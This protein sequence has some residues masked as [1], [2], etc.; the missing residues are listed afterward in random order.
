[1][2][3][4]FQDH[5]KQLIEFEFNSGS[6]QEIPFANMQ[7][8]TL[9]QNVDPYNDVGNLRFGLKGESFL[10]KY[11]NETPDFPMLA[12]GAGNFGS[13]KTTVE[14]VVGKQREEIY[15][16]ANHQARFF[17][18]FTQGERTQVP[19]IMIAPYKNSEL[20]NLPGSSFTVEI[21]YYPEKPA[22]PNDN[23]CNLTLTGSTYLSN[24]F[25]DSDLLSFHSISQDQAVLHNVYGNPTMKDATASFHYR[26][27][28]DYDKIARPTGL[29]SFASERP[30]FYGNPKPVLEIFGMSGSDG[31]H[32]VD[33]FPVSLSRNDPGDGS[34]PPAWKRPGVLSASVGY[35]LSCS[36]WN[37]S[38][39]S[40]RTGSYGPYTSSLKFDQY[41][42]KNGFI[43]GV[44][45]Y[46][47][48]E[49]GN[50]HF[51]TWS[52]DDP[53]Q[54]NNNTTGSLWT[55]VTG[56]QN[57]RKLGKNL[58]LIQLGGKITPGDINYMANIYPVVS[59]SPRDIHRGTAGGLQE[60]ISGS[61]PYYGGIKELRIWNTAL[62]HNTLGTWS[63]KE[64]DQSHPFVE[65]NLVGYWKFE[66][67][68]GNPEFK[69]VGRGATA[70]ITSPTDFPWHLPTSS[71]VLKNASH[72]GKQHAWFFC[73]PQSGSGYLPNNDTSSYT[74]MDKVSFFP[75][76]SAP[77]ITR[78]ITK[79]N[80]DGVPIDVD[81]VLTIPAAQ[82]STATNP[83]WYTDKWNPFLVVSA[84]KKLGGSGI[85]TGSAQFKLD[86]RRV[87]AAPVISGSGLGTGI[88]SFGDADF[89]SA[90]GWPAIDRDDNNR[91]IRP[92]MYAVP[93]GYSVDGTASF[94]VYWTDNSSGSIFPVENTSNA[95]NRSCGVVA[96][97]DGISTLRDVTYAGLHNLYV[98]YASAH[99]YP[100]GTLDIASTAK[101]SRAA[102][103]VTGSGFYNAW[104]M[105]SGSLRVTRLQLDCRANFNE[106]NSSTN[107]TFA[108]AFSK[109]T[110]SLG[111][112]GSVTYISGIG[113]YDDSD[114]L[115]AVGKIAIPIRKEPAQAITTKLR[116]DL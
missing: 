100:I 85:K 62:D 41:G 67:P 38:Y 68:I 104:G 103:A 25:I 24:S 42:A 96:Y 29:T 1:M 72:A 13:L 39:I 65:K 54:I 18:T 45:N 59:E 9:V 110:S 23:L 21:K 47:K 116:L 17:T 12:S 109:V 49:R 73:Q 37:Y 30:R 69:A 95:S 3:K 114:N 97:G 83:F 5:D 4:R 82:T 55:N 64:L 20:Y 70:K 40:W 113:L 74:A 105:Y 84:P 111:N 78:T 71:F 112:T 2:F 19:V 43:G 6:F 44:V 31:A 10:P 88:H 60:G 61:N 115:I 57:F 89:V 79:R 32:H 106:F 48:D 26:F 58:G 35:H 87:I 94:N 36:N 34:R 66:M 98:Y 80:D 14:K 7:D 86:L 107:K 91:V 51:A 77:G 90:D 92:A 75:G 102:E 99:D 52:V 8:Y 27:A 101:T 46:T 81:Q 28:G 22:G 63:M 50:E 11:F 56:S 53:G 16:L 76:L 93:R 108:K 15:G 33:N